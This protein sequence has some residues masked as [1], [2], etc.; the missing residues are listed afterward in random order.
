MIIAI[1]AMVL[2]LGV[3]LLI[4]LCRPLETVI[5]VL[6]IHLGVHV[7]QMRLVRVR[8]GRY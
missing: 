1:F 8:L 5:G 6:R 7:G 3:I 2:V 4:E